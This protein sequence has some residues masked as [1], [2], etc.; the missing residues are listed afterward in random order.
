MKKINRLL[1]YDIPLFCVQSLCS[2]LP[3]NV[4]FLRLRGLLFSFFLGSCGKDFR[5]G[6]KVTFYNPINIHIGSHVY[7]AYGCWINGADRI[8]LEDEVLL[9]PYCILAAS[10]HTRI[11]QSFRYGRTKSAPILVKKGSWL[12][13]QVILLAGSQVGIGSVIAANTLVR[14]IVPDNVIYGSDINPKILKNLE[15]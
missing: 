5:C 15:S 7:I 14:G 2:I 4:I 13:A 10:N 8:T 3:D 9:G 1:R 11:G 6:R 12:G